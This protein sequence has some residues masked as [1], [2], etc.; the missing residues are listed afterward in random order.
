M[1]GKFK[2]IT[3]EIDGNTKPLEAALKK[4]DRAT[5]DL[6]RELRNVNKAL[7]INPTSVSLWSEKQ[8][9]LTQQVDETKN[10]L[11]TLRKTQAQMDADNVDKNSEAYREVQRE[12]AV[13]EAQLKKFEAEL[14]K[15]GNVKLKALSEQFK[16]VG[17]KMQDTGKNLSQKVTLPLAAIGGASLKAGADFDTAMSQVAAT[18]GKTVGEIGELRDFAK[19]MGATTAFSATQAAEGLNYMALAGYDAETSMQMLPTVLD[20]AAAGAMELGAA[21][22]MVTDAQSALGLSTTETTDLVDQMAKA[23]STTNTSVSQLGEAMLTVGGTAKMMKGGTQELSQVL[24]L[25]ADNGI[26]GSEG[27]TALR[28]ILLSLSAPTD[29]AAQEL[30]KLGVSVFDS[31]GNMRSMQDIIGDLNGALGSLT[32]EDRTK[33]LANI[34]NKRDLK[35]VN[36]LLGTDAERWDEVGTAISNFSGAA[37]QMADTQLDN[38]A[39]SLTLLKS[40]LEGAGIAIS[41]VLAPYVKA[42]AEWLQGLVQRFNELSPTA[43]RVITIVG[44]I[45]AAIGPLLVILGVLTSSVGSIIGLVGRIAPLLSGTGGAIGALSSGALLPIIGVIA[46][47]I[48]VGVLLYKNWDK[49]TAA[50]IALK[51]KVVATFNEF[52]AKVVATFNAIKDAIIT[53][54]QNA[55]DKVKG[56]IDRI[57]GFFPIKVGNI[58]GNIKLPHFKLSG[59]LSINPPSVPHLSIDWYKKGG[60]FDSPSVIGVGEAGSEAV[61]PLDTLWKKLDR[62]ADSSTGGGITINVYASQGMD[63]NELARVIEKKL[64]TMQKQR[65]MVWG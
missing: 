56:I 50:A 46:A 24:G 25:L 55:I 1:A 11:E 6:D 42:L 36:A 30:D 43:Q 41:D 14:R 27:G 58:F 51:N 3:I 59:K 53:P 9:L 39:G 13:T 29:K 12:I 48:A 44:V 47:V 65:Q 57:K 7:K 15:V 28:N 19:E 49:I 63:V 5:K 52:K 16:Q 17:Q 8:K 54:I 33:A 38:M 31:E 34:F 18:S 60:I 23:S 40:S 45:A 32:S 35:S 10:K 2:G 62:I 64:V 21:S 4:V 20:L 26:K 22:D 37:S 61:V